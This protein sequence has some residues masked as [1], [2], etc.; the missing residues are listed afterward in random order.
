MTPSWGE[1]RAVDAPGRGGSA[2]SIPG[3]SN[4]P[5][6]DT[7]S[8]IEVV[9]CSVRRG[10]PVEIGPLADRDVAGVEIWQAGEF[11]DMFRLAG[12]LEVTSGGML[13]CPSSTELEEGI[14]LVV[15]VTL[16]PPEG[17]HPRDMPPAYRPPQATI[18]EVVDGEPDEDP[19]RVGDT[20]RSLLEEREK[21]L[22]AGVGEGPVE[23]GALVFVKD[24]YMTQRLHGGHFEVIPDRAGR[25]ECR[26][27]GPAADIGNFELPTDSHPAGGPESGPER[28]AVSRHT[29]QCNKGRID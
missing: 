13:T 23:C 24:I 14:Y 7:D 6:G 28:R 17:S 11:E 2:L 3:M 12:P 29:L 1:H 25:V 18:F 16:R 5:L 9:R 10:D 8:P 26:S 21:K 4:G 19:Q 27:I 15:G 22:S 20:Y